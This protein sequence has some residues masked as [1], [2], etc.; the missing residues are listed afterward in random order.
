MWDFNTQRNLEEKLIDREINFP[1]N[2]EAELEHHDKSVKGK[3]MDMFG[4]E[5]DED[6]YFDDYNPLIKEGNV[7]Y[8][9]PLSQSTPFGKNKEALPPVFTDKE[10]FAIYESVRYADE[11]TY[12]EE[13]AN[14]IKEKIHE[15]MKNSRGLL[16]WL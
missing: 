10:L 5:W 12:R 3:V 9:P 14:S 1:N 4:I 13:E 15:Y 2:L 6:D 11:Q 8:K 7:G 16:S